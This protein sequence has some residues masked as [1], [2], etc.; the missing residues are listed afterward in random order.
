MPAL[1]IIS[2]IWVLCSSSKLADRMSRTSDLLKN[3]GEALLE[4]TKERFA[5]ETDPDGAK[6]TP[7]KPVTVA[8]RG[9]ANPILMRS[10]ALKGSIDYQV[11]GSTL[12]VGPSSVYGAVHQF[13]HTFQVG[14]GG[15]KGKG[16]K[17]A[18]GGK[19]V[20]VPARPYIGIGKADREAVKET[21]QDW[22][23]LDG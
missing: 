5:D 9:S 21:T 7:L 19:G 23:D 22:F 15:K 12:K 6:W 17:R 1:S 11:E 2:A 13:G 16:K 4:T 14:G 20:T 18:S 3:I 10:G 8:E